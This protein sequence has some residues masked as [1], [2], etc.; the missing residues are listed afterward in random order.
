MSQPDYMEPK[1][2]RTPWGW[3]IGGGLFVLLFGSCVY[4]LMGIFA[5][6]GEVQPLDDAFIA[7][8]IEDGLPAADDSIYA[9]G[10]GVTEADVQ[11]VREMITN[12][13]AMN[14]I[15]QASCNAE[16][17]TG[18]EKSGQFVYCNRSVDFEVSNSTVST[19]WVKQD[20]VWKLERFNVNI[21]DITAYS[22]AVAAKAVEA[23]EVDKEEQE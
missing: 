10:A 22:D 18:T 11:A 20:D 5:N 13:G 3:L 16:S 2:S 12:L 4:A 19:T 14:E 9:K 8:A 15:G 1:K 23:V 21:A 6:I 7:Q 17:S